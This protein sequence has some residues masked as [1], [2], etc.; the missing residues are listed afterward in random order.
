MFLGWLELITPRHRVDILVT[1]LGMVK[2]FPHPFTGVGKTLDH[3]GIFVPLGTSPP[4]GDNHQDG[5]F[6]CQCV[7]G[8]GH[9]LH[10]V[11][12][13]TRL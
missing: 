6:G 8:F 10:P 1:L 13:G 3:T 5:S 9:H 4:T 12:T 2:C 7:C 11:T